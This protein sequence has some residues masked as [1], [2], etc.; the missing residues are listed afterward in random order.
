[1]SH[2]AC[3]CNVNM[4]NKQTVSEPLTDS[5]TEHWHT[6]CWLSVGATSQTYEPSMGQLGVKITVQ[7]EMTASE[8]WPVSHEVILRSMTSPIHSY[9]P[10]FRLH[11]YKQPRLDNAGYKS[12]I[13][14]SRPTAR[15]FQCLA[16]IQAMLGNVW[17]K[18]CFVGTG[19]VVQIHMCHYIIRQPCREVSRGDIDELQTS[20]RCRCNVTS[21]ATAS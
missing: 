8:V 15:R 10:V 2:I 12:V 19:D 7:N 9:M 20:L 13:V 14:H 6:L 16:Y 11:D 17:G 1:M 4:I 3:L 5:S 18:Q 21:V